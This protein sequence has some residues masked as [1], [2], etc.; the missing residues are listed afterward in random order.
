LRTD[1]RL[2]IL[3]LTRR[4]QRISLN[5]LSREIRIARTS[6]VSE[7][8][9]LQARSAIAISKE[10]LELDAR[11][12]IILAEELIHSGGDPQKVSRFLD[13][14]EFENFA[15]DSFEENGYLTAKHVVFKTQM[16]RREVDILAWNDTFLFAVDC[17]HWLQ[18]L[19]PART[20]DAVRAQVERSNALAGQPEIL[21]RYGILQ[22]SQRKVAPAILT[23]VEGSQKVVDGVPIVPVSKLMSFLYG[24]SPVDETL[25]M[26]RVKDLQMVTL[27]PQKPKG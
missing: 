19:S 6:L 18:G 13:W 26:F 5:E 7:L 15:V 14:R 12:R 1:L 10:H 24:V 27:T 20:R 17:K 16:G 3:E 23:L 25:R 9:A 22:P 21:C 2:K 11:Q 4:R 8:E